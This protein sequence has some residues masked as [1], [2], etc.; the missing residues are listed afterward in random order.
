MNNQSTQN[1]HHAN[2]SLN[3]LEIREQRL[4][5]ESRPTHLWLAV[6]GKCN[7]SCAHC[8][9][10]PGRGSTRTRDLVDLDW[11]VFEY[12]EKELFPYL[13]TCVM[14][15][16]NRGEP[17]YAKEWD[18]YC[19]RLLQFPMKLEI[20]TNGVLLTGERI[21]KLIDHSVDIRVS[22]DGATEETLKLIR[23]VN[24]SKLV[25]RLEE[26]KENREK[27]PHSTSRIAFN[28]AACYKNVYELPS[29]IELGARLGID[30][31][32][33]MHLMPQTE[34]QRYQS[35]YYHMDTYNRIR[36]KAARLAKEKGLKLD[37]P[38]PFNCGSI[39][40]VESIP[41]QKETKKILRKYCLLPWNSVSIT[42]KGT[43]EPCCVGAMRQMGDL[44]KQ[45]FHEIW[46]GKRYQKL[47][48]EMITHR[49][50]RGCKNCSF[51]FFERY[52]ENLD[53]SI[54][55]DIGPAASYPVGIM[56]RK[57]IKA[58]I[59]KSPLGS[60]FIHSLIDYYRRF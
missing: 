60:K 52:T 29:L 22:I 21:K 6:S 45:S 23:G 5:L 13:K 9:G 39:S 58:L 37:I 41:K 11:K 10:I 26:I 36:D 59:E 54:L 48:K 2:E 46:N 53:A 1:L 34:S 4:L 12:L 14:G 32:V 16:N 35:L 3:H 55:S 17:L 18:R 42:N 20:C 25:Q 33:V 7:L 47:R 56:L 51:R 50:T 30:E 49:Q 28:F 38:P 57:E 44:H 24:L 43:I 15:G 40:A 8:L 27:H 31:I 19:D